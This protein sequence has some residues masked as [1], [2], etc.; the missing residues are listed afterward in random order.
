[1]RRLAFIGLA[2]LILALT[3]A[4]LA[5]PGSF[6]IDWWTTDGGGG[7]ASGGS[8]SLNGTAGQPDAGPLLSGGNYTAAGGFWTVET[9]HRLYLPII[10][11]K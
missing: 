9:Q 11:R 8:Y 2:L 5:G 3:A 7:L 4:A 10:I 1:M 6:Q